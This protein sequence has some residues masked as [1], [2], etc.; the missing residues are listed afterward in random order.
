MFLFV[1][2][3]WLI[4]YHFHI[5]D[6][7]GII[8]ILNGGYSGE[9][10]PNL[11]FMSSLLGRAL[12][13]LY[14][15]SPDINWYSLALFACNFASIF[16]IELHLFKY[17]RGNLILMTA[18]ILASLLFFPFF[19]SS[20]TFTTAGFLAG[21][22]ALLAL[23]TGTF[24]AGNFKVPLLLGLWL[25]L[26]FL[27]REESF[28]GVCLLAA[29]LWLLPLVKD[30]KR[31]LAFSL[32]AAA[33]I[34]AG[35]ASDYFAYRS[36]QWQAFLTQS[37]ALY[38]LNKPFP[39]PE[40][41]PA[42]IKRT[43]WSENDLAI[44]VKYWWTLNEEKYSA[45]KLENAAE[46]IRGNRTQQFGSPPGEW[47]KQA[48]KIRDTFPPYA[49]ASLFLFLAICVLNFGRWARV[50]VQSGLLL[51][52]FA[53]SLYTQMF[54]KFPERI[55]IPFFF[56]YCCTAMVLHVYPRT[57][58]RDSKRWTAYIACFL[59]AAAA[60]ATV[61]KFRDFTQIKTAFVNNRKADFERIMG[62][63][64]R[65]PEDGVLIMMWTFPYEAFPVFSHV[66][67][68]KPSSIL[69]VGWPVQSPLFSAPLRR[70]GFSSGHDFEQRL[71]RLSRLYLFA[72][73]DFFELFRNYIKENSGVNLTKETLAEFD[74][75]NGELSRIV[76][77]M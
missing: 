50:G 38:K 68:K 71:T 51:A 74:L 66:H 53:V 10:S 17:L 32:G 1:W 14:Q 30:F 24:P 69:F 15:L 12:V 47:L 34:F 75:R 67:F 77:E 76:P 73:K 46:A 31:V 11:V 55:A 2:S 54:V 23:F 4:P 33:L 13:A 45:Q 9:N 43:G 36:P 40:D 60:F 26:S 42:I 6:D 18:A 52:F 59:I 37:A 19:I 8:L 35:L 48:K 5:N 63:M 58:N 70:L 21:F 7:I 28:W 16:L 22:S 44:L 27:I 56:F 72:T 3:Y 25:G 49:D 39:V 20:L 64:N 65:L 57:N 29:P 41:F 62:A 61:P